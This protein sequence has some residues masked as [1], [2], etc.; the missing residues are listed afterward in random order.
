MRETARRLDR[1]LRAGEVSGR[2]QRRGE[3]VLRGAPGMKA[4]AHRSE[5]LAQ[6]RG[7][8]WRNAERPCHLLLVQSEQLASGGSG[9]EYARGAGDVPAHVVMLGKDRQPDAALRF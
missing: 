7:L 1:A 9:A 6:A 8:C 4:L 5:H 3:A 2:E